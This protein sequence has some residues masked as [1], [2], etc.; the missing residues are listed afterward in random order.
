[1]MNDVT[2]W[3]M[4]ASAAENGLMLY[5]SGGNAD[6][7]LVWLDRTGKKIETIADKFANLMGA[8]ISPQGDRVALQIDVGIND[9][10][11]LDF[12]RG[13]RT[14]L[15]FGPVQNTTPVWSPDGKWIAYASLRNGHSNLYRKRSD[16]S[17][18]EEV[19]LENDEADSL[20]DWSPDGKYLLYSHGTNGMDTQ[21]W[22]VALEGERKPWMVVAHAAVLYGAR[23]SP[24]GKWLAYES[25]ESGTVQLYI[26]PFRGGQGKWQVTSQGSSGP[27]WTRNGKELF[28]MDPGFNL[29]VISFKEVEGAPQLGAPQQI[30]ITTSA[31]TVFYDISPDGK[32]ILI[33][34]VAQQV[35]PSVTVVTNFAGSL[36]K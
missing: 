18:A 36:K 8:H 34:H 20:E 30:P 32:K 19:L 10:W 21:L 13:V 26:V 35:S 1:V 11:V 5:G 15:T 3:H 12:A 14:R 6:L 17:G 2:T 23:L 27:A 24:D 22:A 28:Y 29:Y 7:Q 33:D 16:G 31:P 25:N 9:I 4:D